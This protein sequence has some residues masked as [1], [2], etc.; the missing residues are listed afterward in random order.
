M[1]LDMVAQYGAR[2][3]IYRGE[4][5][6]LGVG[7]KT[8]HQLLDIWLK[9]MKDSAFDLLKQVK[10]HHFP[11]YITAGIQEVLR[12]RQYHCFKARCSSNRYKVKRG[13]IKEA[14]L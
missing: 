8:V 6:W 10:Y 12:R 4:Y 11:N 7:D 13:V 1:F 5:N 2:M 3:L 14:V 9:H